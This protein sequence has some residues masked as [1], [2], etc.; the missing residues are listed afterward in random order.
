MDHPKISKKTAEGKYIV[1]LKISFDTGSG[2]G[3]AFKIVQF[4]VDQV[5]NLP[6]RTQAILSAL[7]KGIMVF[8]PTSNN[9]NLSNTDGIV[10][11][12]RRDMAD[13]CS[14]ASV[15]EVHHTDNVGAKPFSSQGAIMDTTEE[16]KNSN[17]TEVEILEPVHSNNSSHRILHG[18]N[19]VEEAGLREDQ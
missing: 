3:T 13:Q 19:V 7:E 4:N 12:S 15:G 5:E 17:V 10:E 14:R 9:P 11:I 6:K 16:H 18:R 8:S 1:N 2:A